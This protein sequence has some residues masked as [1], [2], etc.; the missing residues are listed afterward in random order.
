MSS[1]IY[2][3]KKCGVRFD[4]P[5]LIITY[6]ITTTGKLHQRTMPLRNF[7]K[8]SSV[9]R[10][11]EELKENSRHSKYLSG[12]S[13]RQLQKLL[14]IIRDKLNGLSL[15]ESLE[16]NVKLDTIDPNE[17]LNK[18]D[19]DILKRKKAAM[20]EEFLKNKKKPGDEGYVYDVQVEFTGA[21]ET[22]GWD[23]DDSE[24][25]F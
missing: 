23:S 6:V 13:E 9:A 2:Q 8:Q 19:E 12:M 10:L 7:T 24:Q 20:D 4:P 15:D 11:A 21:I 17:D 22:S 14:T 16:K 3:L 5:A 25:D 18:V 1:S